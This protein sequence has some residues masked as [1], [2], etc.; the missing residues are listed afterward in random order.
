MEMT[1]Y[2]INKKCDV[3]LCKRTA[4]ARSKSGKHFCE[5]HIRMLIG[6]QVK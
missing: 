6:E 4:K 2:L 5:V 1:N 3:P